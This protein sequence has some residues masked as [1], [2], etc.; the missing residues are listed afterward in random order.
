MDVRFALVLS[1]CGCASASIPG[2]MNLEQDI[3]SQVY[4]LST[5]EETGG[6]YDSTTTADRPVAFADWDF[7]AQNA[8]PNWQV[9]GSHFSTMSDTLLYAE[10]SVSGSVGPDSAD[11]SLNWA[12]G[13][14]SYKV[15]FEVVGP[16]VLNL[17]AILEASRFSNAKVEIR[18]ERNNVLIYSAE[19]T[20]GTLH[21]DEQIT[22]S[23][24]NP[25][26]YIFQVYSNISMLNVEGNYSASYSASLS[27][28][29]AP[30]SLGLLVIGG[31]V[32]VR[33]RR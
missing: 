11:H 9:E 31:L 26:I 15:R 4:T 30:S 18:K 1:I 25:R 21:I 5:V 32:G 22:L 6:G 13:T 12:L 28:V 16:T 19:A 14:N 27:A 17:N 2:V 8:I 29:P 24:L 7:Q 33:R 10:G 23:P 3:R 20:T